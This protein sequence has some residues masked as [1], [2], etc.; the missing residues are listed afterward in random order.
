L[1]TVQHELES[2]RAELAVLKLTLDIVDADLATEQINHWGTRD[3]LLTTQNTLTTTNNSLTAA[4]LNTV[5]VNT[6]LVTVRQELD[7]A[8]TGDLSDMSCPTFSGRQLDDAILH[9][10]T[11]KL[12]LSTRKLLARA[13]ALYGLLL[14]EERLKVEIS[15]FASSQ[16]DS[17][18]LWFNNLV[19]NVDAA[20]S[21]G[22]IETLTELCAA[23]QPHFIFDPAQKWHHLANIFRKRQAV[24]KKSEEY[25]RRVQEDGIKARATE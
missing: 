4:L 9:V 17:A 11:F 18:T 13:P 15:Y 3:T 14:N 23:L 20:H 25:I 1:V 8:G 5:V 2:K 10:R 22:T 19:I 21:A 6:Q 16:R 12:W 7:F 24:R